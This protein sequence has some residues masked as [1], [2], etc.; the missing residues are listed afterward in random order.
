MSVPHGGDGL[1]HVRSADGTLIAV[2]QVTHGPRSLV[3]MPGGTNGRR[4]WS[5]ATQLVGER[6]AC[7]LMDRRGK[8]D[9]GDTNPYS[10]EREYEDITAV[11][12]S[13]GEDV[14]L[15][16]NSSAAVCLL[17]AAA[18]GLQAR[19]LIVYEPPWPVESQPSQ[20]EIF[21]EMDRLVSI[22]ERDEAVTVG[23]RELVG[24]PAAAVEGMKAA[25]E[26]WSERV[27][28][29][30][31]W[32]REGRELERLPVGTAALTKITTPTLLL[33]GELSPDHLRRRTAAIADALPHVTV[34]QLQGQHHAA[35]QSAPQL[36]ADAI[37]EFLD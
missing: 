16:A 9:S 22:G 15:A 5:E 2:E 20:S 27:A 29:V 3:T 23:L 24:L 18:R 25:P 1:E 33:D 6:F 21:D 10:F 11:A 28:N 31:A 30:H 36:V 26:L 8:G 37:R 4:L 13:I 19:A 35:L 32:P 17:G 14:V 34:V 7:W 12:A